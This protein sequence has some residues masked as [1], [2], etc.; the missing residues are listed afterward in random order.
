MVIWNCLRAA[1]IPGRHTFS[2]TGYNMG[3]YV[4]LQ[5]KIPYHPHPSMLLS[6]NWAQQPDTHCL[7]L[8]VTLELTD[9]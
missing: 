7:Q 8:Q 2:S 9:M 1:G 3:L 6:Q 5:S 4:T